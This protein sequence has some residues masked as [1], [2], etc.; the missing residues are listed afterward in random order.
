MRICYLL[1]FVFFLA[2]M[3]LGGDPAAAQT[4]VV[5]VGGPNDTSA[6]E[7]RQAYSRNMLYAEVGG[8]AG[9][10]SIN[11]ERWLDDRWSVRVGGT[12]H[13]LGLVGEPVEMMGPVFGASRRL[14]SWGV[15]HVET[16]A[17]MHPILAKGTYDCFLRCSTEEAEAREGE[18]FTK[19]LLLASPS[20]GMRLQRARGGPV[21]R[22]SQMA[23][24]GVNP[25]D[26]ST[27]AVGWGGVSLGWSF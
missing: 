23:L 18:P 20:V 19:V 6:T 1:T 21:L 25:G 16:G 15:L 17:A 10:Y 24:L 4:T 27:V 8:A 14:L 12:W 9:L 13:R 2:G 22:Y 5:V 26:G 7:G 11:Y 3:A